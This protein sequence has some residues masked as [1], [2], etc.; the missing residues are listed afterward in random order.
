MIGVFLHPGKSPALN[1]RSDS[2]PRILTLYKKDFYNI[3]FVE[4]TMKKQNSN[5]QNVIWCILK[6]FL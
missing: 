1:G 2:T 3:M 4:E 6:D 5:V